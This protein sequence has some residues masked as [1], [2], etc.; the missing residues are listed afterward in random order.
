MKIA[1]T[2]SSGT[3]KTT[4]AKYISE[5]FNIPLNPVGSRSVAASMGF[6]NPY[7]VDKAS[8]AVYDALRDS[9]EGEKKAA[10][11][12]LLAYDGHETTC[13]G[14]FQMELQAQKIAWEREHNSFVTDRSTVDDFV[15][16]ALHGHEHITEE[17]I[18]AAKKHFAEYDLVFLTP[19]NVFISNKPDPVRNMDWNYSRLFETM[20]FPLA[21]EW[22]SQG[23]YM[24][25]VT[26]TGSDDLL[27]GRKNRAWLAV[28][29]LRTLL[30]SE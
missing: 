21:H 1:F 11:A 3:G 5:E 26:P 8:L 19:M 14:L 22:K 24:R 2:G 16:C 7:D 23:G 6:K 29:Y 17:Y 18:K 15:Y 27:E 28:E 13:R 10:T 9:D 30:K 4:L 20:A 25:R 12:A